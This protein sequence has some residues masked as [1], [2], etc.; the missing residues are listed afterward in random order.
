MRLQVLADFNN[1]RT[2]TDKGSRNEVNALLATK[3]QVLFVFLSQCWQCDRNARQVN[4]FVFAQVTVVQHFTDNLVTFDSGHFHTDQ[5]I[6]YQYGVAHGQ[7]SGEAFV[8]DSNDFVVTDNG[9]VGGE[10]ESL[11]SFQGNVVATFQLDGADFWAFGIQ[12][13]SGFLTGFAQ[14]VAQVL[15]ALTVFSIVAVGEV[16]THYVHASVKHFA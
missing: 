7:V 4:A 13:D 1:V 5:T 6:V 8:G 15:D 12:Q 10:S 16:Q 11:T 2:F 3:D 14:H 9:F